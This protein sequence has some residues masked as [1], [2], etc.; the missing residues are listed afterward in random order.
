MCVCAKKTPLSSHTRGLF[1]FT[2]PF[3]KKQAWAIMQTHK[4]PELTGTPS[5]QMYCISVLR[6]SMLQ[7]HFT[8]ENSRGNVVRPQPCLDPLAEKLEIKT[9]LSR[10][11]WLLSW[12]RKSIYNIPCHVAVNRENCRYI[13]ST[14]RPLPCYNFNFVRWKWNGFRVLRHF[15]ERT[16]SGDMFSLFSMCSKCKNH[17]VV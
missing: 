3:T 2:L 7:F 17:V 13:W 16:L 12:M 11:I 4:A 6:Q 15:P 10:P 14:W 8:H 1:T 9:F 5:N